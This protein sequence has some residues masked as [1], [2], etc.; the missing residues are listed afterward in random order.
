MGRNNL[1]PDR[2]AD[3][4]NLLEAGK[5]YGWPY[6]YDDNLPNPEFN[7]PSKCAG[8]VPP[9]FKFPPHWAPLGT[10]FYNWVTFPPSY[11]GDLLVAFH[12]TARDQ[13]Q[14][15]N[16][17]NVARVRFKRGRPVGM[18]DL[19]RGWNANS[20]VWGR[21]AGLLLL[22]DGSLLISDDAGGRIFR[23]RY[24]G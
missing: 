4:L 5:S 19:V 15:L 23:L 18:E 1:G 10:A 14:T 21:P 22:P 17:Y 20:D 7:D 11:Q 16:G 6:C 3:E 8:A 9:V 13:V 12:G 24:T 2:V